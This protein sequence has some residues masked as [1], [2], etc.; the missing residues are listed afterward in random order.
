MLVVLSG[1]I[2]M[3]ECNSVFAWL[4]FSWVMGVITVFWLKY[5]TVF[6]SNTSNKMWF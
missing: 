2:A 3:S 4:V 5:C 1:A 6:K